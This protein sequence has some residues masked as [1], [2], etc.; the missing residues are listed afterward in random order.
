M[1]MASLQWQERGSE[2]EALHRRVGPR[3]G[4]WANVM[5]VR[6]TNTDKG[7]RGRRINLQYCAPRPRQQ[8]QDM[9]ASALSDALVWTLA[10]DKHRGQGRRPS[11]CMWVCVSKKTWRWRR[12]EGW[13]AESGEGRMRG[14]NRW[15]M[16]E[17]NADISRQSS[18][19]G[20]VCRCIS[21]TVLIR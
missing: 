19:L 10:I 18:L 4:E 8:R 21:L 1:P 5:V 7:W 11:V 12:A 9:K 17:D 2:S 3:F 14:N 20:K 16:A 13:S 6:F 15:A